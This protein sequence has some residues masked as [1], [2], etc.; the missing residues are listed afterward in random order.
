MSVL[1]E[2][3][4]FTSIMKISQLFSR[5]VHTHCKYGSLNQTK[6][7]MN[8]LHIVIFVGFQHIN[9]P[10]ID[11]TKF[12]RQNLRYERLKAGVDISL[13]IPHYGSLPTVNTVFCFTFEDL[14][15]QNQNVLGL[16]LLR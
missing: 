3:I 6:G 5:G 16:I 14:L 8:V 10:R 11:G 9:L 15:K 4:T 2:G 12:P 7:V 1:W 13:C